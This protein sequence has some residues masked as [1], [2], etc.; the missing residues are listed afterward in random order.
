M[1]NVYPRV[2]VCHDFSPLSKIAGLLQSSGLVE[3]WTVPAVFAEHYTMQSR[4]VALYSVL[5][6]RENWERS[7]Q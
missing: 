3:R 5:G 1:L 7:S 4:A 6:Q 2:Q